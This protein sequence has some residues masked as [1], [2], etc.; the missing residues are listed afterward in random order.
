PARKGGSQSPSVVA[1]KRCAE[2]N[3][4]L[5]KEVGLRLQDLSSPSDVEYLYRVS[6]EQVAMLLDEEAETLATNN[7]PVTIANLKASL[8][9]ILNPQNTTRGQGGGF[10]SQANANLV[11][12]GGT[13][14][15]RSTF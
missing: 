2:K 15:I 6:S 3:G 12:S 4:V 5:V 13:T 8:N 1:L 10:Q 7:T 14:Y 9:R 11:S